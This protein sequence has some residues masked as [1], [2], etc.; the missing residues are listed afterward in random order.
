[1][2]IWMRRYYIK[3]IS[4]YNAEKNRAQEDAHREAGIK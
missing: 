2:P 3:Q 4:D 1:M